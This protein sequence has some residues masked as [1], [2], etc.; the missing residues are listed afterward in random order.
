MERKRPH[1][2]AN[3]NPNFYYF[4]RVDFFYVLRFFFLYRV[5][6]IYRRI[7]NCLRHGILSYTYIYTECIIRHYV[8]SGFSKKKQFRPKMKYRAA[9][10]WTIFNFT[11]VQV[12]KQKKITVF[13]GRVYVFERLF[14]SIY[15][16]WSATLPTLTCWIFN[17]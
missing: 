7:F 9:F 1:G 17:I 16:F 10:L 12:Y 8:R 14:H 5:I 13:N 15:K 4:A 6:Y 3:T 11:K 2:I